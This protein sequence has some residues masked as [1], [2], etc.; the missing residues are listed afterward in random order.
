[1]THWLRLVYQKSYKKYDLRYTGLD[2]RKKQSK[3]KYSKQEVCMSLQYLQKNMRSEVQFL[4]ADNTKVF[5]KLI[6]SL[7]VCRASHAQNTQNNKFAISLQ[8]LKENMKDKVQFLPA[9]KHRKF[10]QIIFHFRRVWPGIPKLF[11]IKDSSFFAINILRKKRVLK[12][13]FLHADKYKSF[14][15]IDTMI[16]MGWLRI[17]AVS[18]IAGLPCLCSASKNKL[19]MKLIY[20]M[21]IKITS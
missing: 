18:K 13:I 9:D 1:M 4:L 10:L 20:G 5:Y 19:D 7:W 6:V 21:Q 8:Y 3:N 15:Q 11:K 17:P 16:L 14:Q 12:Q 2:H